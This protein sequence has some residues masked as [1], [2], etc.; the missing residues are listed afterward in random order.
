MTLKSVKIHLG[1]GCKEERVCFPQGIRWKYAQLLKYSNCQN[2]HVLGLNKY[3]S[4][5]SYYKNSK[6]EIDMFAGQFL[7]DNTTSNHE[8][9]TYYN[10]S[11]EKDKT[12]NELTL[13]LQ[14]M[15][16]WRHNDD[17]DVIVQVFFE[18]ATDDKSINYCYG[19]E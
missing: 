19:V 4:A 1:G 8:V 3:F 5:S 18:F 15:D 14:R 9:Q 7:L 17:I 12:V 10:I 6:G 16:G 11:T 13:Y 2:V